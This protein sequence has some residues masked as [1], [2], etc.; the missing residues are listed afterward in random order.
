MKD[1]PWVL[2]TLHSA[3]YSTRT[4]PLPIYIDRLYK[5]KSTEAIS[6]VKK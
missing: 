5:S 6:Q 2:W 4:V 1:E 3:V